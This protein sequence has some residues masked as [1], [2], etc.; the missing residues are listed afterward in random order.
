ML[1]K[2][3]TGDVMTFNSCNSLK[4]VT[5][6]D[7]N[8]YYRFLSL[9]PGD[10]LTR[11]KRAV[12]KLTFELHPDGL[13]GRFDSR[14]WEFLQASKTTLLN[15]VTKEEYDRTNPGPYLDGYMVARYEAQ[16]R[17]SG[18]TSFDTRNKGEGKE[19]SPKNYKEEVQ[20]YPLCDDDSVIDTVEEEDSQSRLRTLQ[21]SIQRWYNVLRVERPYLVFVGDTTT[22]YD[23]GGVDV[24]VLR[25]SESDETL[26]L[27]VSRVVVGQGSLGWLVYCSLISGS[28][29]SLSAYGERAFHISS[30]PTRGRVRYSSRNS[31]P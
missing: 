13:R 1:E 25:G 30:T 17:E 6:F 2:L 28:E 3:S 12:R 15:P 9:H 23:E 27:L 22:S 10:S 14:V 4:L 7:P 8:G 19:S 20:D 24:Y 18:V 16:L 5:K 31:L 11:V 29:V 21:C 26:A